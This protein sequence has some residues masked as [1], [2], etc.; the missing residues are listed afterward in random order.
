MS[1]Y[2]I[3]T[4]LDSDDAEGGNKEDNDDCWI[5]QLSLLLGCAS[6]ERRMVRNR[7]LA[8]KKTNNGFIKHVHPESILLNAAPVF[9]ILDVSGM[10][11]ISMHV[12]KL[13]T[14]QKK[15]HWFKYVKYLKYM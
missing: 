7:Q 2:F 12:Q 14:Y 9:W 6:L 10:D 1:I 13:A 3:L 8:Q 4:H 15:K 11:V 5:E